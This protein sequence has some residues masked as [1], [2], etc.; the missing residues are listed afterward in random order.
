MERNSYKTL[1]KMFTY[2]L[3]VIV[4]GR[5]VDIQYSNWDSGH[6]NTAHDCVVVSQH[7]YWNSWSCN[8]PQKYVCQS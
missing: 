3:V 1:C 8:K 2:I 4:D 6:P 5:S 7:N